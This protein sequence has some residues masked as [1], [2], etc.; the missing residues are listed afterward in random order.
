VS[1]AVH[2]AFED[3]KR[4][5]RQRLAERLLAAALLLQAEAKRDLSRANP[6]PHDSPAPQGEFPRARTF[7]LRDSIAVDAASPAEVEANGQRVRVGYL[8]GAAYGGI[9]ARKGWKGV[10]DTY[11][12]VEKRIAKILG[13]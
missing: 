11:R 13:V 4:R 12:R 5:A 8:P 9:L 7:N 3:F 6:A 10:F 2:D 1:P